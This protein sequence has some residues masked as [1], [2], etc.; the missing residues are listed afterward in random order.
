MV[1][2]ESARAGLDEAG[3]SV[4]LAWILAQLGRMQ[5]LRG[6][7]AAALAT[8]DRALALAEIVDAEEVFIHALTSKSIGLIYEGRPRETRLLLEGALERARAADL[9]VAWLRAANNLGVLLQD[10]DQHT[11][12]VELSGELEAMARQ[13]GLR[14]Q[15]GAARLGAITPLALLGRW[16]EALARA[17]EFEELDASEVVRSE[18]L[19]IVRILC[20]QGDVPGAERVLAATGWARNAEQSELRAGFLS[21]E[22]RLLRAQGRPG[23][24]LA[25]AEQ[26]LELRRG[27]SFMS[28]WTKHNLAEAIEAALALGDL[29]KA[30]ELLNLV[31]TLQPGELTPSLRAHRARFRARVDAAL[32]REEGVDGNFRSAEAIFREFGFAFYLAAT[33][34]EHGEWLAGLGRQGEAEP[35]VAEARETFERLEARPWLERAAGLLDLAHDR[36]QSGAHRS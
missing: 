6:D 25:A 16:P 20:E 23:D 26:G 13:L 12:L 33:Q 31:E 27:L 14:E 7:Y 19:A 5:A 34:L 18:L 36:P 10:L 30:E 3:A 32:G 8:L 35:L 21:T 24:A 15:L 9:R 17:A 11:E 29:D 4:E 2:L 22:A 28:I 1:R